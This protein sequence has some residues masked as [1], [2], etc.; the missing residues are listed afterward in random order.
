MAYGILGPG[1]SVVGWI[2]F[3][4]P[5]PGPFVLQ[6]HFPLGANGL[7]ADETVAL[8]PIE[9]ASPDPVEPANPS[10][11]S[12]RLPNLGY[13]A[14]LSSSNYSG[15]GAQLPG[16][17]IT[18]VTG[19]WVQPTAHCNGT[20]TSAAAIWVGIDDGGLRDLE[21]VGTEALC[22]AGSS[23]PAYIAWYEMYPLPQVAV[24]DVI[25]GD[26]YTASVTKRGDVWTLTL[27]DT[28]T[29]DAF[30]TDETRA[31]EAV[32]A[33]WVVEAPS[34]VLSDGALRI[35]PLASFARITMTGCLA[36]AGGTRRVVADPHWAHYRFDMR[37]GSNVA[38]ATTSALTHAGT[39][40]TST[41]RHR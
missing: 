37:T 28:R 15:Y 14:A 33:L 30:T 6:Y 13:P 36:V 19:S 11:G 21:Q 22:H 3:L 7:T 24:T 32:Q 38:K 27:K 31:S 4:V 1:Q 9:P 20:E 8:E 25:P 16:T 34:R 17:A 2:S 23:R 39:S 40:F 35:L 29:G 41:W 26:R 10:P 18:S 5:D 12:A